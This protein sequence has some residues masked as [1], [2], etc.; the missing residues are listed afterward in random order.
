MG[1]QEALSKVGDYDYP[2]GFKTVTSSNISA[3]RFVP[4]NKEFHPKKGRECLKNFPD[5]KGVMVI[6]FKGDKF[7]RYP[8]VPYIVYHNLVNATSVGTY[9]ANNIRDRFK[10]EK[11]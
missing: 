3:V 4:Y 7:Y 11:L 10:G 6:K 1:K 5:A 9:F 2:K 8:D